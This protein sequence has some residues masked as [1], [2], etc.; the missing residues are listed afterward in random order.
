MRRMRTWQVRNVVIQAEPDGPYPSNFK[1]TTHQVYANIDSD[2]DA[3][4][5]IAELMVALDEAREYAFS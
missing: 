1:V 2:D 3:A 4:E 5:F